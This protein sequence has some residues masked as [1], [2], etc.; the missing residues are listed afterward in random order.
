MPIAMPCE[1]CTFSVHQVPHTRLLSGMSMTNPLTHN[2]LPYW[3]LVARLL[4]DFR[5]ES[6]DWTDGHRTGSRR[7]V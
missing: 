6:Y 2:A 5:E 3:P 1:K 4:L 7:K